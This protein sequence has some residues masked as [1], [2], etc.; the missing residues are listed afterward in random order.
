MKYV[1]RYTAGNKDYRKD[2]GEG[3]ESFIFQLNPEEWI[4]IISAKNLHKL[5]TE[6]QKTTAKGLKQE[7]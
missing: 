4:C 3:T 7:T 1:G 6:K 2:C 5:F